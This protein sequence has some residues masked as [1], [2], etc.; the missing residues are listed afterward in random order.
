MNQQDFER[1]HTAYWQA[2]EALIASL[3]KNK[4][5]DTNSAGE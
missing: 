5:A 2:T 3:N 4:S 1:Q